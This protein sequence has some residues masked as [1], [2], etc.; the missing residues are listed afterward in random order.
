M[1]TCVI[2]LVIGDTKVEC[3]R[4]SAETDRHSTAGCTN[5]RKTCLFAMVVWREAQSTSLGAH[6][7]HALRGVHHHMRSD[8]D[9][10]FV[11]AFWRRR[12]HMAGSRGRHCFRVRCFRAS[13]HQHSWKISINILTFQKW[14]PGKT[15]KLKLFH[16]ERRPPQSSRERNR[17]DL[18]KR[19]RPLQLVA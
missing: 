17:R 3:R 7:N 5:T 11:P 10:R 1:K 19:T 6:R 9:S 16:F 15:W 8:F 14:T 4:D 18:E 2:N 13:L 12:S